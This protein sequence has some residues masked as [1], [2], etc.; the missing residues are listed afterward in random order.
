MAHTSHPSIAPPGDLIPLVV[1][2]RLL[3]VS[4]ETLRRRGRAGRIREFRDSTGRRRYSLADVRAQGPQVVH[5]EP[6][7]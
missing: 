4:E 2:A 1:A 5:T 7:G 3:G 6:P